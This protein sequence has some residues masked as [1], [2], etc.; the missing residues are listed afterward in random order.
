MKCRVCGKETKI[1][2]KS[3]N[4]AICEDCFLK[5]LWGRVDETIRKYSMFER[6]EKVYI[7]KENNNASALVNILND[8]GYE[9]EVVGKI[10]N[11]P[12]GGLLAIGNLLE[13]EVARAIWRI[14]NWDISYDILPVYQQGNIRVVKPLCLIIEEELFHYKKIKGIKEKEKGVSIVKEKIKQNRLLSAGFWLAFYKSLV[15]ENDKLKV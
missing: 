14:L 5:R 12:P 7:L 9:V 11:V 10:K 15:R 1:K 4:L 2:I 3:Y 6:E 8:M 13:D